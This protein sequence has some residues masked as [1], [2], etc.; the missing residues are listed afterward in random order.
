[1]PELPEVETMRRGIAGIVGG[2]I[3]GVEKLRCPR[4]PIHVAPRLAAWRRRVIGQ[5]VTAV[6][7]I[8][9]RVVV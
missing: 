5:R 7:R 2:A 3:R 1:M 9:K 6:D 4:K 8:G